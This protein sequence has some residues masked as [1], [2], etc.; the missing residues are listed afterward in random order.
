MRVVPDSLL[1]DLTVPFRSINGRLLMESQA[2]NGLERWLDN[3]AL[4]TATAPVVPEAMVESTMTWGDPSDHLSRGRLRLVPLPW[5]F[6]P[7]QHF[8]HHRQVGALFETEVAQHR[9]L[10]LASLGWWG[11]W[12]QLAVESARRQRRPYS[13][14]L[15]WVLHE[16][17]QARGRSPVRNAYSM[18]RRHVV[19][20][21]VAKALRGAHLGLFHGRSVYDA[22]A[23][24]CRQP[25]LIHDVHLKA[26][27]VIGEQALRERISRRSTDSSTLRV[28]YVGRVHDMKGPFDWL[29]SLGAFVAREPTG[30]QLEAVWLGDGP[31]LQEARA[32][33]HKAGLTARV[34]FAGFEGDRSR[35]LNFLRGL[36]VFVFCHLS[37]ESPRCLIEALMSGVP[38]VGYESAY[39]R[40]LTQQDGGGL[41]VRLGDKEA[42]AHALLGL[43]ADPSR[44][45]GLSIQARAS[46]TRFSDEVVFRHRSD[47]IKRHLPEKY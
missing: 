45:D 30:L 17:V 35:V 10:A 32:R 37:P 46:G 47:L 3:F 1:L 33:T 8:L 14:G 16:M 43:A 24:L 19:E 5:A 26:G 39:A 40:D 12:G 31:L 28:G 2:L 7:G 21:R 11:S 44:L 15:D 25:E 42:L 13:I 34:A 29:D 18:V 22:Y 9:Y 20:R 4:V 27:D 6:T 38:L 41:F 23:H 36:D